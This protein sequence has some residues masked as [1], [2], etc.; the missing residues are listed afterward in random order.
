MPQIRLDNCKNCGVKIDETNS[1]YN[2]HSRLNSCKACYNKYKR[3]VNKENYQ[4]HVDEVKQYHFS[5]HLK[6]RYKIDADEY[7]WKLERQLHGC[8]ICKLPFNEERRVVIDHNHTTDGVRDFLCQRCNT[9]LGHVE[10][11]EELVSE[12]IE[13]LKRHA[14]RTA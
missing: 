3:R 9:I 12:C 4:K 6:N 7:T 14:V 13:Y 8:A 10:N 5:Y 2:K 1:V 11:N